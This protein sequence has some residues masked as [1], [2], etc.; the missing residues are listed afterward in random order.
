MSTVNEDIQPAESEAQTDKTAQAIKEKK[1]KLERLKEQRAKLAQQ[2]RDEEIAQSAKTR[3]LR[4]HRLIQ[5]GVLLSTKYEA[6]SK[7]QITDITDE[8]FEAVLKS[9]ET[10]LE[11]I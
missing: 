10:K 2:I 7:I 6:V 9:F 1:T 5:L 11:K 4:T 8:Q 3:K